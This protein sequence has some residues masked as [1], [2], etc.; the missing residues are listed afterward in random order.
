MPIPLDRDVDVPVT[1]VLLGDPVAVLAGT[2]V[3]LTATEIHLVLPA[4]A[5]P[6]R[7]LVASGQGEKLS[8]RISSV[9]GTRVIADRGEVHGTDA[10]AAPRVPARAGLRWRTDTGWAETAI[11]DLSVAGVR[12]AAEVAPPPLGARI[13]LS[14]RIGSATHPVVALVRRSEASPHGCV[15][16]AEF[17]EI[18]DEAS[19]AIADLT[20]GGS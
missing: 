3:R 14:L 15:V 10:R 19:D 5:G 11:A 8:G 7:R 18:P 4:G 1:V 6:G 13:D 12:F 9:V 20:L 16:G 2:L 17:A